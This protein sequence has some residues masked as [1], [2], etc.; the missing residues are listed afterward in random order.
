MN[1]VT[2]HDTLGQL[3]A[4][5]PGRSRVFERWGLD[6]CCGGKKTLQTACEEQHLELKDLLADLK[7]NDISVPVPETDWRTAP[8]G[9]LADHIVATHHA[10][11][12]EAL[13]RLTFLTEKVRD[14]HGSRH[15]ELIELAAIFAAFRVELENHAEKEEQI[16]FPFIKQLEIPGTRPAFHC[17]SVNNPIHVMEAEHEEAGTALAKMRTL[18]H[19]F[20]PPSDACNTYRAMLDALAEL[21]ADMHLHVHKE[22][23]ILFPRASALEADSA[24]K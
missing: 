14:A 11:L 6:Y 8:L 7:Q 24:A 9:V 21:E 5:R 15:P 22:N 17:G 1:P 23:S 19:D 13:P 20:T 16:L 2:M 12:R 4:E 10:Y 18:T 3:V